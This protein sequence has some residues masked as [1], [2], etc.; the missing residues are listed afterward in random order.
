[1]L[2]FKMS[3][4][5]IMVTITTTITVA[6]TMIQYDDDDDFVHCVNGRNRQTLKRKRMKWRNVNKNTSMVQNKKKNMCNERIFAIGF[7]F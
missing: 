1:M 3:S 5:N 6:A 2:F 4:A 7:F